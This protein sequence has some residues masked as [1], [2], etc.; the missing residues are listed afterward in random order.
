MSP[1]KQM[2]LAVL[3]A[4]IAFGGV[5]YWY[6]TIT[7]MSTRLVKAE[8]EL[9]SS[10]IQM[11]GALTDA[12]RLAA[13][14][15]TIEQYFVGEDNV[16]AFINVLESRVRAR[17][18]T[19]SIASVSKSGTG[20]ETALALAVTVTGTFEQVMQTVGAIEHLPYATKLTSVNIVRD[21]A[22]KW[23]A[24]VKLSVG[25]SSKKP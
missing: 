12:S 21:P 17:G 4:L 6:Y 8:E 14:E 13:D 11:P 16:P 5:G 18:A 1:I 20:L 15:A 22:V 2:A 3:V 7:L 25:L 19:I 10:K 23:R 9:R 24:D